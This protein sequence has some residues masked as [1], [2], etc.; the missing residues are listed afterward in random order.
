MFN[1]FYTV[2]TCSGNRRKFNHCASYS[3]ELLLKRTS[4]FS[5]D[6]LPWSCRRWRRICPMAHIYLLFGCWNRRQPSP[7][8]KR[9]W[10]VWYMEMSHVG[11]LLVRQKNKSIPRD[12]MCVC[13]CVWECLAVCMAQLQGDDSNLQPVTGCFSKQQITCHLPP[14]SSHSL[15]RVYSAQQ[16]ICDPWS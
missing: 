10:V 7:T 9:K 1:G 4:L 5:V 8:F 2:S 3:L 13:V 14:S 15:P 11:C 6:T 16:Q 12:R